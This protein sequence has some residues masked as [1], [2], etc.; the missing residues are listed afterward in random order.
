MAALHSKWIDFLDQQHRYPTGLFGQVIGKRMERQHAPETAWTIDRLQ[1]QSTDRI[2]ELG[3]GTGHGLARA[4]QQTHQGRV[5]G[6]DLSATM[7]HAATRRNAAAIRAKRVALL[8]ANVSAFPFAA[9]HFDK[10][11]SIHTFYFWPDPL[12]VFANLTHVLKDH[13]TIIVTFAT[14]QILPTG[15]WTYWPLHEQVEALVQKLQQWDLTSVALERGP[16]SRQYNNV[17]IVLRK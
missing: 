4:A 11:F 14:A 8:R 6:L 16:P 9:P 1:L 2:L 3:F 17:A 13:G 7:I 12:G 5:V 10:I 15:E